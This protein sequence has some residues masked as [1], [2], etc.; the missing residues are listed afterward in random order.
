MSKLAITG[1]TAL[2]L[3]AL[4][5]VHA[6]IPS[7][8]DQERVSEADL[9][10]FTDRR[11]EVIKAALQLTPAQEKYWPAVEGAIRA[12][13]DARR[14]RLATVGARISE[15]R[16]SNPIELL[17]ARADAL[18]QRAASLKKLAD[19][20]QPLYASL[21]QSQKIRLRLL[22]VFALREMRNAADS[23]LFQSEDESEE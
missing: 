22:T 12:R 3:G 16:D 5:P 8:S 7:A 9:K 18:A 1:L 21:D 10:A 19:A 23:R 11:I 14:A 6:Q 17:Q 2:F 13:A 20:W 15:Q 4:S